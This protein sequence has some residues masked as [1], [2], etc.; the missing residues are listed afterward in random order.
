MRLPVQFVIS[1]VFNVEKIS[2]SQYADNDLFQENHFG[3]VSV[4]FR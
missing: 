3:D 2:V 1:S 4:T